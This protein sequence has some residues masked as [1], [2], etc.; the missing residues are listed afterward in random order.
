MAIS[1]SVWY[2]SE[3]VYLRLLPEQAT[4]DMN[5]L[6]DWLKQQVQNSRVAY[7]HVIIADIQNNQYVAKRTAVRQYAPNQL[8]DHE[9][10]NKALHQLQ[11]LGLITIW[12]GIDRAHYITLATDVFGTPRFQY[13]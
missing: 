5:L 2:A 7:N 11:A 10:L 3:F 13:A 6:E 12:K 9:R 4:Q 8:R 1:I